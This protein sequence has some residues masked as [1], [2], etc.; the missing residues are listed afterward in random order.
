MKK[1]FASEKKARTESHAQ[2]ITYGCLTLLSL[3]T[4]IS[5]LYILYRRCRNRRSSSPVLSLEKSLNSDFFEN[6]PSMTEELLKKRM[7]GEVYAIEE[8]Q[9]SNTSTDSEDFRVKI[10]EN[11]TSSNSQSQDD[12][13][14]I[15]SN[16]EKM[17]LK[18][19][20]SEDSDFNS[21]REPGLTPKKKNRK[22]S[23]KGL[24]EFKKTKTQIS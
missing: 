3:I 7:E 5:I 12:V 15:K 20:E 23:S 8:P 16:V 17:Y 19:L 4:L 21:L 2:Y 6:R 22:K 1:L 9:E 10:G 13:N 24:K 14:S 11:L 18:T